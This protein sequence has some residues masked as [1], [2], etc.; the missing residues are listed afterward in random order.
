MCGIF[1]CVVA[2]ECEGECEWEGCREQVWRRGPDL[3]GE[4]RL[5][6]E[7]AGRQ[8]VTAC[9][10]V[11]WLQGER[12]TPQPLQDQAGNILLWNGDIFSLSEDW[13]GREPGQS[14]TTALAARLAGCTRPEEVLHS[15]SAVRGPWAMVYLQHAT[16][17]LWFGRDCLGR[18]SLLLSR[19]AGRLTLSSCA[20]VG[21]AAGWQ[22]VPA[23]GLF[24]CTLEPDGGLAGIVLHPWH[25][26]PLGPLLQDCTVSPLTLPS[27]VRMELLPEEPDPLPTAP[28]PGP[29]LFDRLLERAELN[30]AVDKLSRLL[31]A[32]VATR[33]SHQPGRCRDCVVELSEPAQPCH[34][35][36][37]GVLFSGGL[38]SGALAHLAAGEG[39]VLAPPC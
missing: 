31:R 5:E 24:S 3:R 30:A 36:A 26:R 28:P 27:P 20:P 21:S 34:H 15:V 18:H 39:V 25:G 29:D 37:V 33:I 17:T 11:L 13:G 10:S 7:Q 16:R 1:F 23:T 12:P 14:D 2:A 22:E 9:S 4:L 8:A 32:A 38:D 35:A 19:K 6:V